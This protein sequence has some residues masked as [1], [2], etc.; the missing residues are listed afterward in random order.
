[1][2]A[3]KRETAQTNLKWLVSSVTKKVT[4]PEIVHKVEVVEGQWAVIIATKKV[5]YLETVQTQNKAMELVVQV[6]ITVTKKVTCQ[7][8][9]LSQGQVVEV[10]DVEEL[11]EEVGY[12]ENIILHLKHWDF[13]MYSG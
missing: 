11:L 2:K 9:V 3:T 6:V 1:M 10:E 12:F 8:I 7:E 5:I 4:C 13:N